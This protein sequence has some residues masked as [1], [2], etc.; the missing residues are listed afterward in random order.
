MRFLFELPV[1]EFINEQLFT[2]DWDDILL[3]AERLSGKSIIIFGILVISV[4]G[5]LLRDYVM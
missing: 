2:V 1:H 3:Q 4:H 5:V